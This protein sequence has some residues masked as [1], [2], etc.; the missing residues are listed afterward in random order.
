MSI[1][2]THCHYNLEPLFSGKPWIFSEK[3]LAPIAS[4]NWQT[5]WQKAQQAG[6]IA[7]L[8][9]GAGLESSQKAVTIAEQTPQ[10]YASVGIHPTDEHS[11]NEQELEAEFHQLEQLA[12]NPAVVAIG[13]T[14][15]DYF[16]LKETPQMSITA[17]IALQK[18]LLI[19]HI[20]LANQQQKTL[21]IHSR[22]QSEQAYWDI[23]ELI[24]THYQFKAPCVFHCFSGPKSFLLKL[25]TLNCFISFAGNVTYP[26]ADKLQELIALIPNDKLLIETDAPFLPPQRFRGQI[27]QPV[28][29]VETAQVL[30]AKF[31][32][33]LEQLLINSYHCFNI[34]PTYA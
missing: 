34:K 27:N 16:N 30:Q 25:L 8:V 29:I 11:F 18:K 3:Q 33:D 4:M 23:L 21:I 2:D 26:S 9:V 14:G 10:L 17:Q 12:Q 19:K 22:D 20:K 6:V 7:S 24:K 32:V 1:F 13:E 5:H 31:N 28:M 15:L